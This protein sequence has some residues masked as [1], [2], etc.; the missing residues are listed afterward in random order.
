MLVE[1]AS[2]VD[3]VEC[4]VEIQKTMDGREAEQSEDQRI[5]YRIGVNV[6]DIVIEGDDILGEGVNI[7][8]RLEGLAAPGGIA[9]AGNV[10][11]QTQGKLKVAFEDGG[12]HK[13][14]NLSRPVRIWRWHPNGETMPGKS[15]NAID[16]SL[17]SLID[18][19]EQPTLA[20]LP[21]MNMSRNEDLD[22]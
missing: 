14:K 20:V 7:A 22:F 12:D 17:K 19:I 11:E 21:F 1:F 16:S 18:S 3:A 15:R 13:V 10:Y 9:I 8:S 6:G 5:R 4:A 2:V